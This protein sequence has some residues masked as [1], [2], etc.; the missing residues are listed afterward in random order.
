MYVGR[1]SFVDPSPAQP[2]SRT[3]TPARTVSDRRRPSRGS[4][5]RKRNV[6]ST[7][8]VRLSRTRTTRRAVDRQDTDV[9]TPSLVVS[10]ASSVVDRTRPPPPS[11]PPRT[12]SRNGA[13]RY[14]SKS[15]NSKSHWPVARAPSRGGGCESLKWP[16]SSVSDAVGTRN[17]WC[18]W[19]PPTSPYRTLRLRSLGRHG[20]TRTI[21]IATRRTQPHRGVAAPTALATVFSTCRAP[22]TADSTIMSS[23]SRRTSCTARELTRRRRLRFFI[24]CRFRTSRTCRRRPSAG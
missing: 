10:A 15:A 12:S 23:V 14:V 18:D 13:D 3:R 8:A 19:Y 20:P 1:N 22:A 24:C 9:R 4:W 5:N 7:A 11:A 2:P 16:P 6:T 17:V 21:V